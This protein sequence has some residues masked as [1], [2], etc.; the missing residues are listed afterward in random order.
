MVSSRSKAKPGSYRKDKKTGKK[1]KRRIDPDKRRY[2]EGDGTEA[3]GLKF[4][5]LHTRTP[6]GRVL[7]DI[8][9]VAG[10][11]P[12]AEARVTVETL[13]LL[14]PDLP[15][16]HFHVHDGAMTAE[17][18]QSLLTELGTVLLN[19]TRAKSNPKI[20]GRSIGNRE[21]DE[22][23]VDVKTIK[24]IDGTDEEL[25]IYQVDG[26]LASWSS[27]RWGIGSSTRCSLRS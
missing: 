9:Y 19:R 16:P 13:R 22:G 3:W 12:A 27:P 17:H 24:R 8:P 11:S 21:P 5:P 26:E 7:L 15:G 6:F 10:V 1:V 2:H 25:R 4:L 20:K 18:N 23:L 14:R